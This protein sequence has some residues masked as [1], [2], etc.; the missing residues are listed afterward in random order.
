MYIYP[1]NIP[2]V[3]QL[4]LSEIRYDLRYSCVASLRYSCVTMQNLSE[5]Q[6]FKHNCFRP[7]SSE[8]MLVVACRLQHYHNYLRNA[9]NAA[10][11]KRIEI[12]SSRRSRR[13]AALDECYSRTIASRFARN[14]EYNH[15]A[16][17]V[18]YDA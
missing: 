3:V 16:L 5:R 17:Y 14:I 10:T 9:D 12:L 18:R 7:V 11:Y 13:S 2:T 4:L 6:G 15:S 1:R 8:I